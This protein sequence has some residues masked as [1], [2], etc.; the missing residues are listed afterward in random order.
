MPRIKVLLTASILVGSGLV[1]GAAP[2]AA[3]E[4]GNSF[5]CSGGTQ[6]APNL[7]HINPGTYDSITITQ[8]CGVELPATGTVRDEG[9]LTL[10][11]GALF[12]AGALQHNPPS[13]NASLIVEG[14][15]RLTDTIFFDIGCGSG[16]G[17]A[18]AG[19]N[20]TLLEGE[21]SSRGS[22]D[23]HMHGVTIEGNLSV[24]GGGGGAY[25]FPDF[26]FS[27]IE[28]SRVEGNVTFADIKSCWLGI[29]RVQVGGNVRVSNNQMADP[30]AI[31]ILTNT[32][33]GNLSCSGN[34]LFDRTTP[35]VP[36]VAH[37]PWDSFEG[38]APTD[39]RTPAPNSVEGHRSGQ[40]VTANP[41]TGPF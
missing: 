24:R 11:G 9:R 25:C 10:N 32:I 34:Q 5:R 28:D 41:G 19:S 40:C 6:A 22:V 21:F 13:P 7:V 2:A 33:D 38:P 1:I 16:K 29:A 20:Q 30:D 37:S 39:A 8:F 27:N 15:T 26:H 36:A 14:D 18:Y 3:E 35:S 31:E 23:V 17:C 12:N 4:S